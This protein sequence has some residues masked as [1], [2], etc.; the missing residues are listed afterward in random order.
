MK[1]EFETVDI[2]IIKTKTK[3]CDPLS[4]TKPSLFEPFV[5]VKVFCRFYATLA[6][7][8]SPK[9]RKTRINRTKRL[10]KVQD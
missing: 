6:D 3:C 8:E 5:S 7:F 9:I 4:D 2:I 1:G 10:R